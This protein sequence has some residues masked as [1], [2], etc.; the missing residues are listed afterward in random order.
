MTRPGA[1]AIV[2]IGLHAAFFLAL[3]WIPEP[4]PLVVEEEI[5]STPIEIIP[6]QGEETAKPGEPIAIANDVADDEQV[7]APPIAAPLPAGPSSR[8]SSRKRARTEPLGE[9]A[10]DPAAATVPSADIDTKAGTRPSSSALALHGLRDLD[11]TR[12]T[13]PSPRFSPSAIGPATSTAKGVDDGEPGIV[14]PVDRGKPRTLGEAGFVRDKKGNFVYHPPAKNFVAK[15]LPDGRVHFKDK[16]IKPVKD[17]IGVTLPDLYVIVR[18]A[19]KRELWARE[20]TQLLKNTFEL[21][22]AVAIAFAEDNIDRRLKALYRDLI[23]AWSADRPAPARRK[24]IFDRWDECDESMRVKL[25]GFEDATDSRIDDLRRTAG[26][27]A[28]DEIHGFIRKH[29]PKGSEDAYGDPEIVELNRKRKSKARF[30]P[31]ADPE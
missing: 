26:Q 15:M 25:P 29:I 5:G 9:R 7:A 17:G 22:L 14:G 23:D 30:A 28:R 8:S 13:V 11:D 24:T 19:Q 6:W 21:R 4:A 16:I 10:I 27:R 12:A 18:K 31:Y 20:K 1:I 3:A 2:S